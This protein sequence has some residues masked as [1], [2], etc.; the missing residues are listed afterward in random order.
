MSIRMGDK[1]VSYQGI[2]PLSSIM[3]L[4]GDAVMLAKMGSADA[5]ERLIGQIGFS[6]AAAVTE[7]S[8]L[9]GLATIGDL[10]NPKNMT[11]RGFESSVYNTLN[12]FVPMSGAR[13][14]LYNT[15]RPYVMEVDGELQRA[16]NVATGGLVLQGATK[17]DPLNGEE[18]PSFAGNFFN[19]VSPVRI[20]PADNDPVKKMLSDINFRIPRNTTGL[21]G[22]E[23]TA[24]DRNQLTRTMYELG[25]R[26][27]LEAVMNTPGFKEA[28]AAHRGRTFSPDNPDQMPPHYRAVWG[29]WTGVRNN[30]LRQMSQ[31]N[32]D[33]RERVLKTKNL[34]RAAR[35][36]R[37]EAVQQIL[38]APQ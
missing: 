31:T 11:P 27:R 8:F 28:A 29:V 14:A 24:N 30:A 17:V 37:Y 19:A 1:W 4:A 3:S 15:L 9:A 13:R 33:F 21:G 5:A 35:A 38:N 34:N 16:L 20:M 25:L 2:E 23:L 6:V 22:V 36:G 12:N 32:M 18:V 7:K 10:L 26:E